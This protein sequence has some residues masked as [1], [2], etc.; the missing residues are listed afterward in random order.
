MNK[1]RKMHSWQNDKSKIWS[2]S[3]WHTYGI[4][5]SITDIHFI[6]QALDTKF[7]SVVCFRNV[8]TWRTVG[9][10]LWMCDVVICLWVCVMILVNVICKIDERDKIRR[11]NAPVYLARQ[12]IKGWLLTKL[13]VGMRPNSSMRSHTRPPDGVRNPSGSGRGGSQLSA[14]RPC[15]HRSCS[16]QD[17]PLRLIVLS[18]DE[19]ETVTRKM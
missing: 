8:C 17:R 13:S 3:N 6:E 1:E 15:D 4:Y 16:H 7:Q 14:T 12:I 2:C 19:H 11:N 10:V 5:K 18:Y 9:N